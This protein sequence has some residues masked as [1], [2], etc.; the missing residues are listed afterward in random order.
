[1]NT[2][3]ASKK[4]KPL[5]EERLQRVADAA[6]AQARKEGAAASEV[7]SKALD[8]AQKSVER[9]HAGKIDMETTLGRLDMIIRAAL[10]A[11]E[12]AAPAALVGKGKSKSKGKA[13]TKLKLVPAPELAPDTTPETAPAGSEAQASDAARPPS[14][15]A[16]VN[17]LRKW[18][19]EKRV[20]LFKQW[21]K[22]QPPPTATVSSVCAALA[23]ALCANPDEMPEELKTVAIRRVSK[24][25]EGGSGAQRI[26][27]QVVL[28]D[29][30]LALKKGER[31][32][33]DGFAEACSKHGIDIK[34]MRPA[35][36]EG[37]DKIVPIY[38]KKLLAAKEIV[39]DLGPRIVVEGSKAYLKS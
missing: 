20:E 28:R 6:I 14:Q 8:L 7:A 1:M 10:E 39:G 32:D 30:L 35:R 21:F 18:S 12:Q 11:G 16:V 13:E 29:A 15:R 27:V 3:K 37:V 26:S 23:M 24:P 31:L 22:R 17:A 5:P 33:P 2:M 36:I 19:S 9:T 4:Q 25:R 34:Q 38:V